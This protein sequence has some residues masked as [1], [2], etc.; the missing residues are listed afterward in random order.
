MTCLNKN[1]FLITLQEERDYRGDVN[2]QNFQI[3]KKKCF[4]VIATINCIIRCSFAPSNHFISADGT[5]TSDTIISCNEA[6]GI[7]YK[8][9]NTGVKNGFVQLVSS[10]NLNIPITI[11]FTFYDYEPDI[12]PLVTREKFYGSIT[13]AGTPPV[14]SA[15]FTCNPP[16][17]N[18]GKCMLFT[19]KQG[20]FECSFI[21]PMNYIHPDDDTWQQHRFI[22]SNTDLLQVSSCDRYIQSFNIKLWDYEAEGDPYN[23]QDG[24]M[25]IDFFFLFF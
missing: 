24:I 7:Y 2:L 21:S 13:R 15:S 22:C 8:I 25:P 14:F 18:G 11:L 10:T 17:I 19:S 5:S 6:S 20:T 12:I 9:N 23:P 16:I 1:T 4:S 3:D